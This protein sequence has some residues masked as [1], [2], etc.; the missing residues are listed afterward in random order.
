M[1]TTTKVGEGAVVAEG[2]CTIF[3]GFDEFGF[4]LIFACVV[5]QGFG[6]AH[7]THLKFVFATSDF[8]EFSF[9]SRE[10]FFGNWFAVEIYIVVETIGDSRTYGELDAR[11]KFFERLCQDV[12]RRVPESFFTFG[13]IPS[14]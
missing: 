3:E 14:V 8:Q 12:G 7:R 5:R 1:S 10:I 9:D 4:V 11:V 2:N 13:V 6:F